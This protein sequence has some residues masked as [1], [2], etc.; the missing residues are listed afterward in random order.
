MKATQQFI[1]LC[2]DT[3]GQAHTWICESKTLCSDWAWL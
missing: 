2:E 1:A 3:L